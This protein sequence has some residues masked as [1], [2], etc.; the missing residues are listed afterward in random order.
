MSI[1]SK[2]KK[3]VPSSIWE[4]LH[5]TRG[6]YSNLNDV[7]LVQQHYTS[8]LKGIRKKK[9]INILFFVVESNAWKYDSLYKLM[10]QD[11]HFNPIIL[12]CPQVNRG[13]DYMLERMNTCASYFKNR[14]YHYILTYNPETNEYFDA[15][16]LMPDIICYTNPYKGLIHSEYYIDNFQNSLLCYVNYAYQNHTHEFGFNL[17][18]HQS[19]WRYYVECKYNLSLIKKYS[20][21]NGRNCVVTGYPMY[22]AFKQGTSIGYNWKIHNTQLKRIIWSPHHTIGIQTELIQ[23]S[24]FELY[25]DVMLQLA[26]KYK[27]SIQFAFKPHPLLKEALYRLEG[28]GKKRTDDYYARW[29]NLENGSYIDDEY[30]DLFNT[31]DAMIND[32]GSFT[33]EY[34]YIGKPCLLLNNYDRQKDANKVALKAMQCWYKATT[35]E[36]IEKFIVDVV[37]N[38]HDSLMGKR[39]SFYKKVL[40]PPHGLSVSENILKDIKRELHIK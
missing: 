3:I 18:F 27:D 25:Y 33:I 40:V 21:I 8:I 24:T 4:W 38:G 10:L 1:K 6:K 34:L 16:T 7:R 23:Y 22:D 17:P 28:W 13:Y 9:T 37:L 29:E 30:V 35:A 39:A 12:I 31:S 32:S 14:G 2:I 11:A 36:Q 5:R 15:H 20:P 26:E 19:L